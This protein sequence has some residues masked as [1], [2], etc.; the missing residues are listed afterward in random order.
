MTGGLAASSCS[1]YQQACLALLGSTCDAG[2]PLQYL[3]LRVPCCSK[4]CKTISGTGPNLTS[5]CNCVCYDTLH[6]G[7]TSYD[8]SRGVLVINYHQ[9]AAQKYN[10]PASVAAVRLR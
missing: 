3:L 7:M 1:P 5:G 2:N 6:N 10:F 8:V 4:Y 9:P